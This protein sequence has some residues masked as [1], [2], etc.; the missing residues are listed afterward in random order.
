MRFA[1]VFYALFGRMGAWHTKQAFLPSVFD[2][3]CTCKVNLPAIIQML[4]F[5]PQARPEVSLQP[6]GKLIGVAVN[7]V[8]F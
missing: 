7:T 2:L 4:L 1:V 8:A 3:R 5:V 6:I